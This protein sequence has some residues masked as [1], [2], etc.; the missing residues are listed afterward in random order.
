MKDQ[1]RNFSKTNHEGINPKK[2][3]RGTSKAV[4]CENRTKNVLNSLSFKERGVAW[5][6]SD[7]EESITN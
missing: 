6:R 4:G 2:W 5:R 7:K 1:E 3:K